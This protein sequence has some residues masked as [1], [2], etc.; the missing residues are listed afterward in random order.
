MIIMEKKYDTICLSG[1]GVKGI[2]FIGALEYI[3]ENKYIELQSINNFVGTSI[4]SMVSFFLSL[5]Y[6]IQEIKEFIMDFNFTKLIPEINIENI[7]LLHGVDTGEK[8]MLIVS[9]FLKEKYNMDDITFEEHQKL[10]N[11]KLTIIGTNFTKSCEE[12]FNYELTPNMSVLTAIRISISIPIMFTPVHYNDNYYIDGG[13]VNNFP[14]NQCNPNTTL[15]IYIKNSNNNMLENIIS[16]SLGCIS[17]ITD[18]I[19]MKHCINNNYDIIEIKNYNAEFT[20]FELTSEIK[21]KLYILGI[22]MA[23]TFKKNPIIIKT[24]DQST[25]TE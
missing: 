11:K 4:G 21:Q 3:E 1:G 22:D 13:V 23:K 6:T 2:S 12:V 17:I 24:Q 7:L 10:T 5:D 20:N 8:I 25:Q 9:H 19:S 15:G 18:G 16:L 14:L